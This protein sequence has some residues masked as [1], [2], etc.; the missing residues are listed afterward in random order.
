MRILLIDDDPVVLQATRRVLSSVGEVTTLSDPKEIF[1][2]DLGQFDII[3]SD[4]DMP[5]MS[6]R[7]VLL[8]FM[9]EHPDKLNRF[10][11]HSSSSEAQQ[12]AQ[13]MNIRFIPKPTE[14]NEMQEIIS[15]L[16]INEEID[17]I[18]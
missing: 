18:Q 13:E 16:N 8:Y 6:G 1:N 15:N 14:I 3:V 4:F 10:V 9:N 11:F 12:L 17:E 2:L 5:Q 7:G